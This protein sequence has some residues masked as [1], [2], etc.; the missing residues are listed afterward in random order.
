MNGEGQGH[1]QSIVI[2]GSLMTLGVVAIMFGAVADLVGRNR[3]LLEQTLERLHK[4]EDTLRSGATNETLTKQQAEE[5]RDG[6]NG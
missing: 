5:L 4:L 1:L 3:Q 2:G 6:T